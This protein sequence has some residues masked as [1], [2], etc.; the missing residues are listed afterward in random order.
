MFNLD[1]HISVVGDLENE[2]EERLA[3]LVRFSISGHNHLVPN[4]PAISDPV[5]HVN[6]RTW[7]NLD[8]IRIRRFQ[9]RYERFLRTFD[10]FVVTHTPSFVEIFAPFDKPILG[11]VSTRYEAPYTDQ[12]EQWQRLNVL[13]TDMIKGGQLTLVA[14]NRADGDYFQF[15][16]GARIPVIPSLCEGKTRW[17]G[18][19]RKRVTICRDDILRAKIGRQSSYEPIEALGKPYEWQDLMDCLEVLVIPQNVS[20][21]TLFELATAGVPVAVPSQALLKKLK[22]EYPGVLG[23]LTYAELK[24]IRV[25]DVSSSPINWES[26]TYLD[27][28]LERADF[29]DLDLMPNVRVI[30]ALDELEVDDAYIYERESRFRELVIARNNQI[31]AMRRDLFDRWLGLFPLSNSE[32]GSSTD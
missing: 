6:Q 31:R 1:L 23:E 8:P 22:T 30:D 20:T 16:T 24:Q 10:G 12:P 11:V 4:R 27:W 3:Q 19:S 26:D 17:S 29:Y 28:W 7:V 21:M 5:A 25:S 32:H 2:F 15:F 14:N 9:N 18:A 13:L